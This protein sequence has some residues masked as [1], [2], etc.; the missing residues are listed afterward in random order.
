[1]GNVSGRRDEGGPSGNKGEE[2]MEYAHVSHYAHSPFPE[3]MVRSPPHSPRA[4][5]SPLLFT[6]Q[7]PIYPLQR[8]DV[9]LQIQ[10]NS[11]TQNANQNDETGIPT[12]ITWSFDGKQVAIE[13]SWDNWKTRDFLQKSGKD[14]TIVKVLPSGFY[15][16][17]FIVDGQWRYSP[18]L[19]QEHD[20]SGNIFH[21][22]DLQDF[23]PEVL[24]NFFGSESPSSPVSTYNNS[25]FRIEDFNE[26]L[27]ELPPL[28]QQSPL[29]QSSA[30]RDSHESLEK[31]LAAVLN[32]L[33]IQKVRTGQPLVA[34]SSTH[35]FRTKY[36][37]AVLYKPLKKVKK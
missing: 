28:L 31:P 8:P 5:P 6:H 36:V 35:R 24:D 3:S 29:D 4:Y 22:L 17:R 27:P 9:M 14:F 7:V 26:K 30:F 15:H 2:Y 34:L 25:T 18:D 21:V 32:H 20:D 10:S 12:M 16:Y 1:M 33:Y 13:G 19:P 23:V 11:L 37:T